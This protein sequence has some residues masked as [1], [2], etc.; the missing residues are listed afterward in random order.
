MSISGRSISNIH[1]VQ[2]RQPYN[3][4][5]VVFKNSTEVELALRNIDGKKIRGIYIKIYRSSEEQYRYY[6]KNLPNIPETYLNQRPN[7]LSRI[8]SV[9]NLG[10]S[11]KISSFEMFE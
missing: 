5:F 3:E 1:F 4:A 7:G 6:C 9:P 10:K 11:E 2:I 8:N